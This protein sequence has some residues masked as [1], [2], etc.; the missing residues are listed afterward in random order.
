METRP[1]G[2]TDEPWDYI[3][4][5]QVSQNS[6]LIDTYF[7]YLTDLIKYVR[8]EA[9]NPDVQLILH[10]TWAYAQDASHTGFTNYNRDQLFMYQSIV[11]SV[12]QAAART[13]ITKIIPSGTALQNARSSWLG[14]QFCRDGFHL[15]ISLG[16]YVAACTW[17][18]ALTGIPVLGNPSFP[19]EL[20]KEEVKIAQTAAHLA[21]VQP[22]QITDMGRLD[23]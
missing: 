17:F 15:Q 21:V 16:R 13:G 23:F 14:D 6:G 12:N 19:P 18:E 22:F 9:L 8:R 7:P 5:Q 20:A 10:Q 1:Q 3:S 2:L 11:K 4:F